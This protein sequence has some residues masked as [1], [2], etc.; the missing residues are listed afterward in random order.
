MTPI[1]QLQ[2]K[3]APIREELVRHPIYKSVQTIEQLRIFAENHVFAVWDFMS[4]LKD[5]Q[6]SLTC[7]KVPWMPVG[8]ANTR[9]LI[10]EIVIGEESDVDEKGLRMSHFELYLAAMQ[11]MGAD[12]AAIRALIQGLQEGKTLINALSE[13]G[14]VAGTQEFVQQT[15]AFI[16]TQKPHVV[17]SVFTFGREDLIPDMFLAFINEWNGEDSARVA[18]FKYYLERHI[19]VDG[20]HHSHLAMQMVEELCGTDPLKWEEA[21]ESAIAALKSRIALWDAVY[22]QI[23]TLELA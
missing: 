3:I 14:A 15:F 9:Y 2:L 4:L 13:T 23:L 19:E 5:L 20:D 10:N 12:T 22:D 17:A 21:T 11:Q 6:Q 8:S 16:A 7:V 18:K 1:Q